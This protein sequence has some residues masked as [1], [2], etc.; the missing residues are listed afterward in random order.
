MKESQAE[1]QCDKMRCKAESG[2][3]NMLFLYGRQW[4]DV[5]RKRGGRRSY[6][7]PPG[8]LQSHSD[9][10]IANGGDCRPWL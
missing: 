9:S 1:I 4:E 7:V 2:A 3:T 10:G 6:G 5:E 8:T